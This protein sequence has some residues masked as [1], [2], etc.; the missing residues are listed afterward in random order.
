LDDG[1]ESNGGDEY[2]EVCANLLIFLID[3]V[4]IG[5]ALEIQFVGT[6]IE[7]LHD[8]L[9]QVKYIGYQHLFTDTNPYI[10]N[11]IF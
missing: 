6:F 4:R 11:Y 8:I 7:Y 10:I 2:E 9:L 3:E 1:C 5:M